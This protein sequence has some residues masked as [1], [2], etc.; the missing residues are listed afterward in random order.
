MKST[1][2]KNS[3]LGA[4]AASQKKRNRGPKKKKCVKPV[5]SKDSVSSNWQ[6]FIGT[7]KSLAVNVIS[8]EKTKK[9]PVRKKNPSKVV[10]IDCEMVANE[11]GQEMLAR[12]SV[13]DFNLV[14]LYDKYVKPTGKVGDYRTRF[15]GIRPEDLEN[16][17]DFKEVQQEVR[18]LLHNKFLVGHGLRN[19]L[20]VLQFGH[21]MK[22]IRDTSLFKP[23]RDISDGKTPSLR[24]L[25]KHF[26]NET[27]QEGEHSSVQD[28]TAAM[29]L[30]VKYR[31]TW[32]KALMT[33]NVQ[34]VILP[35]EVET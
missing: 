18:T 7:S 26:L 23:F 15:S 11:E 25:A 4:A 10:A 33:K 32:E 1:K 19:D 3:K 14:C 8:I 20:N 12:V 31:Q 28:A 21:H 29:K 5:I 27:I 24:K 17:A 9:L 35:E 16:A 22:L 30:Y 6:N 34:N 2:G 13:V